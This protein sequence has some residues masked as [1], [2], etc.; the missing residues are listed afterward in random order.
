MNRR[1]APK[2]AEIGIDPHDPSRIDK[3]VSTEEDVAVNFPDLKLTDEEAGEA[4]TPPRQP[5][6]DA[7]GD[8]GEPPRPPRRRR[9]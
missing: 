7:G 4:R 2:R 1:R 6:S 3:W 9:A 8:Q 5:R